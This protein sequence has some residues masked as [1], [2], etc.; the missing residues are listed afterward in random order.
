MRVLGGC[1][2]AVG[3]LLVVAAGAQ[4]GGLEYAGAG[5]QANGRGGAVTGETVVL[6]LGATDQ[7]G[8]GAYYHG[9][10]DTVCMK[11]G[12]TPVPQFGVTMR[13]SERLGIGIGMMFPSVTPQ[14][15]WGGPDGGVISTPMGP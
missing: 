5:S 11:E 14:G 2:I 1:C 6:N 4:A 9:K 3:L 7:G 12:L 10:L 8:E 15:S 13:L